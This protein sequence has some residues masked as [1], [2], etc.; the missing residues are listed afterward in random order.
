MKFI[1]GLQVRAILTVPESAA[2][3][4]VGAARV[5]VMV[6]ALF[7][8]TWRSD[9]TILHAQTL[10]GASSASEI[11]AVVAKAWMDEDQISSDVTVRLWI[12]IDNTSNAD[13]EGVV[14]DEFQTPGFV[15]AGCWIGETPACRNG[16][17][18]PLDVLPTIEKGNH[19]VTWALLKRDGSLPDGGKVVVTGLFQWKAKANP[20][21]KKPAVDSSQLM[22]AAVSSN[23][24][25]LLPTSGTRR[26]GWPRSGILRRIC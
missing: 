26:L 14:F 19:V 11:G 15:R 20:S 10:K 16:S 3:N 17:K 13:I 12:S 21:Q 1:S 9:A 6:L 25:E 23:S 7:V 5:Q 4:R 24:I 2:R 18:Q 8:L 22:T